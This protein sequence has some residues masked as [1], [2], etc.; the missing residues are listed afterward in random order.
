MSASRNSKYYKKKMPEKDAVVKKA[1]EKV[2][3]GCRKGRKKVIP[4]VQ[5][6]HPEIGAFRIRRV[7]VQSGFN[8]F[9]KPRSRRIQAES[10]PLPICLKANEEWAMDFMS[11]ALEN[12]RRIRVFNVVDHYSRFFITSKIYS[13]IPARMVIEHLENAIE[14]YG[15]PE[16][17]RTDNGPEFRSKLFQLWLKGQSIKWEQIQ[18]G[19]P[20]QN[21][22]IERLNRTF[23]ED[24]LDANIFPSIEKAQ[25]IADRFRSEYNEKRPHESIKNL[26]PSK[27]MVA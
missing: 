24:V 1:I 2:L 9:Q 17:I 3:P 23:R 14:M 15:K 8:L 10:N 20:Q 7:Y 5:K 12:G 4:L 18:P 25:Q 11:D 27:L 26:T 6:D 21:G 13:S 22:Y 16:R 19:K